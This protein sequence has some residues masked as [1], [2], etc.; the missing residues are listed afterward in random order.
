[1]LNGNAPRRTSV[2]RNQLSTNAVNPYQPPARAT[3]SQIDVDEDAVRFYTTDANLRFAESHFVLRLHPL[4]LIIVSLLLIAVSSVVMVSSLFFGTLVFGISS[5]AVMV[6]SALI[7]LASVFR[8][9]L[10]LRQRWSN[11]G[12]QD[13][14]ISSVAIDDDDVVLK[15]PS[16]I[17]RWPIESTKTYRTRKG[18]MVSPEPMLCLFVPKKNQSPPPAYDELRTRLGK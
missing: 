18:L 8:T 14:T 11:H 6:I 4:R 16:G 13:G 3:T 2:E 5:I 12:L 10:K 9:K 7:Y 1:L 17:F 15:S